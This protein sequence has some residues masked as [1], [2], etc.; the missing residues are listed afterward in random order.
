[1]EDLEDEVMRSSLN[2]H[3]DMVDF[4]VETG[5]SVD[6]MADVGIKVEMLLVVGPMEDLADVGDRKRKWVGF[7]VV[8][9]VGEELGLV[10][11]LLLLDWWGS[12]WAGLIRSIWKLR[13][14]PRQGK[15]RIWM[16]IGVSVAW[17]LLTMEKSQC[18]FPSVV[19]ERFNLKKTYL[20]RHY[21]VLPLEVMNGWGDGGGAATRRQIGDG[22]HMW[23][24]AW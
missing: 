12:P 19:Y 7:G 5:G 17:L 6:W 9:V 18:T 2:L 16:E 10:A 22:S 20:N 21:G 24:S 23:R 11:W 8:G 13:R 14:L 4:D 15:W 3:T 1:M